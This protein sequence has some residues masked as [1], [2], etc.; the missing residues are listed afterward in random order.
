[1]YLSDIVFWAVYFF[2]LYVSVFLLI[3]FFESRAPPK[4]L[5]ALPTVSV[6]VP[7][8]NEEES[9]GKTL[10]S[11]MKLDY[12]KDLLEII[13]VNDGSKDNTQKVTEGFLRKEN[14][15]KLLLINQKNSG[16]GAAL[17]NGMSRAKGEFIA[18]LDADSMVRSDTLKE[19]IRYFYDGNIAAVSPLMKV[20]Q[21]KTGLQKLQALEY[22]LYGFLKC[23]FSSM[24]SIHVTSGPFSIYRK[25]AIQKLGGFDEKT[26]VEDQEICY[27][28]Q[29][30]HYRIL[31]STAGEVFTIAPKNIRELYN[32]RCRWFK[33]SAMTIYQYRDML[34]NKKY[35]DFGMFQLP[36]LVMGL[37]LPFVTVTLFFKYFIFP[38]ITK[39]S[40]LFLLN[41]KI[42]LPRYSIVE[43]K[44]ILL[45]Y[46]YMKVFIVLLVFAIGLYWM[47]KG[48]KN[49]SERISISQ[50]IPLLLYFVA[51]YII[52]SFIWVGSMFELLILKR[53][54]RW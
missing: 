38:V 18:C 51:Y 39:I 22:V 46:D 20:Y 50:I 12:P 35:G 43:L 28:I 23:L 8:Y 37:I 13:V 11:L 17:N 54:K 2:S 21:P 30:N 41:F 27:R 45:T 16:K 25:S 24:N 34:F 40:N 52:L 15:F 3:T 53:V 49:A 29:R 19:M 31:Q 33:G 26:I 1:M 42:Y 47:L 5:D 48:H 4:R 6:I 7:A 10:E 9:I 32:Q 44:S 14:P 36:T